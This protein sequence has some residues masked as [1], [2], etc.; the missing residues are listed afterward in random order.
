MRMFCKEKKTNT[1]L[2]RVAIDDPRCSGDAFWDSHFLTA[3][4]Y[5]DIAEEER[6]R[7]AAQWLGS[8]DAIYPSAPCCCSYKQHKMKYDLM[9]VASG[10]HAMISYFVDLYNSVGEKVPH[11]GKTTVEEVIEK[12]KA[13]WVDSSKTVYNSC[14]VN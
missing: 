14:R 3:V 6:K 12:Y 9:E 1:N 7:L 5:P 11:M 8:L 10:R 2:I 4:G 13:N